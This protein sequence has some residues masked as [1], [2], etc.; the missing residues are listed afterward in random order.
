VMWCHSFHLLRHDLESPLPCGQVKLPLG[1]CRNRAT[2]RCTIKRRGNCCHRATRPF[3]LVHLS[4]APFVR[5][6]F[7]SATVVNVSRRRTLFRCLYVVFFVSS[8]AFSPSR[9]VSRLTIALSTFF[10]VLSSLCYLLI[11]TFMASTNRESDDCV[12]RR[13]QSLT[14]NRDKKQTKKQTKY[15]SKIFASKLRFHTSLLSLD[16]SFFIT[17]ILF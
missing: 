14:R 8:C 13:R 2:T 10:V 11:H 6:I 12:G 3:S 9:A 4:F 17:I 5:P 7:V 15:Y 16:L 1:Y